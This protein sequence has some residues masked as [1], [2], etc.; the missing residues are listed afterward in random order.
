MIGEIVDILKNDS[1]IATAVG[2]SQIFA[3]QRKQGSGLPAIVVDLIDIKTNETKHQSSDLDF[4]TM[5]VSTYSDNP[6][7]SYDL[8]INCRNE[9]DQY[10]G[11]VNG[12]QLEI[13]FDDLETGMSSEDETFITISEYVVTVKRVFL[14]NHT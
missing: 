12:E 13:R 5:Q 10:V 7:Q 4:I 11:T 3:I 14:T 9:L 8:A 1:T 6:K 2:T